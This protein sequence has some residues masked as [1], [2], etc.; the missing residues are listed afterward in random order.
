MLSCFVQVLG[1]QLAQLV[2]PISSTNI[3]EYVEFAIVAL[4]QLSCVVF[5]PEVLVLGAEVTSESLLAW[6]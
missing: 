6:K 5:L 3:N 1:V 2:K 4:N